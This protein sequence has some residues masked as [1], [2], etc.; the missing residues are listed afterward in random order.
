MFVEHSSK[1]H[2]TT[3]VTM[4][5]TDQ[6]VTVRI[7][8]LYVSFL[9]TK[10]ALNPH[11]ETVRIESEE[12]LSKTCQFDAK[13][14]KKIAMIDFSYFC[15][16]MA[17]KADYKKFQTICD[18]GNWVFPFDDQFDDGVLRNQPKIAKNMVDTLLQSMH[19]DVKAQSL[20]TRPKLVDAHDEICEELKSSTFGNGI[21][22]RYANAMTNYCAGTLR[23]VRDCSDDHVQQPEEMLATRRSSI[24]AWPLYALI[25]YGYE[26]S[27]PDFVFEHPLIQKIEELGVDFVLI[28]ND[29][30]SYAKEEVSCPCM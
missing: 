14:V 15:A 4:G 28:Q 1:T 12:W 9:D 16:I 13:M 19:G 21:F 3:A 26:L 10:P 29:I 7:P 18:W 17:P 8:Q 5:T 27:L 24:G 2:K 22:M 25:E 20:G 11:Y 30:L 6:T 23:Q